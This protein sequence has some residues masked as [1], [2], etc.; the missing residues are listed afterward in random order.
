VCEV[1]FFFNATA[2][3]GHE[4]AVPC[5]WR[6]HTNFLASSPQETSD[7]SFSLKPLC[8]ALCFNTYFTGFILRGAV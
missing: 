6:V 5:R 1:V 3:P 7:M 2:T 8:A 4:L